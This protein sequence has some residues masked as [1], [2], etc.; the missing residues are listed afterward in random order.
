[1]ISNP[2]FVAV[3]S[4]LISV[5][6][7][8]LIIVMMTGCEATLATSNSPLHPPTTPTALQRLGIS[9]SFPADGLIQVQLDTDAITLGDLFNATMKGDFIFAN[10]IRASQVSWVIVQ[11]SNGM[12][13]GP[14]FT[15][16]PSQA[17]LAQRYTMRATGGEPGVPDQL[18]IYDWLE[19]QERE[20][21]SGALIGLIWTAI[22]L[23][24]PNPEWGR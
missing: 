4:V 2:R 8:L 20:L 15:A 23:S 21:V 9:S 17:V 10:I 3:I 7:G 16:P 13:P 11:V 6:G 19:N 1:M 18:F 5:L 14:A 12:F 22:V 24:G